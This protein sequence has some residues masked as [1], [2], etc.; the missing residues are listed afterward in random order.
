MSPYRFSFHLGVRGGLRRN[1]RKSTICTN[2]NFLIFARI[3]N[4]QDLRFDR[5]RNRGVALLCLEEE[6]DVSE[7]TEVEVSLL[8]QS[9]IDKFKL[10]N[11]TL[12]FCNRT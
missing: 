10:L 1:D 2:R 12:Q 5:V 8:V 6:F 3:Q 4:F 11:L 9:I 7:L